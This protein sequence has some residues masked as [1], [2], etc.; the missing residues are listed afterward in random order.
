MKKALFV[1]ATVVLLGVGGFAL[2]ASMLPQSEDPYIPDE[3]PTSVRTL[4]L[5][6]DQFGGCE[7]T[8]D[9]TEEAGT[10][11]GVACPEALPENLSV[12]P[13][14]E[15]ARAVAPDLD[16]HIADSVA[17]AKADSAGVSG[18]ETDTGAGAGAGVGA[19]VTP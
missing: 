10:V 17:E 6:T 4:T 9:I 13:V 5:T 2:Y 15:Q 18:A 11:S 19:G 7:V 16:Q 3:V 12:L 8:V 1:S 14:E